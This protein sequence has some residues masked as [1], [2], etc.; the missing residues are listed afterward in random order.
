MANY[1]NTLNL[2]QKLDQ[3]GRCRFMDREEF[4]DEANFLKIKKLSLWAVERKV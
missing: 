1:F 4:A 2:R 3:L